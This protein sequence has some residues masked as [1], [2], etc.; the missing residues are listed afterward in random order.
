MVEKS[1][2]TAESIVQEDL[3][4]GYALKDRIIRSAKV[5][6]LM[7][8]NPPETPE[9]TPPELPGSEKEPSKNTKETIEKESV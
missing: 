2:D 7:P 9:E 3:I 8:E 1:P 4:K 6:V 5:K